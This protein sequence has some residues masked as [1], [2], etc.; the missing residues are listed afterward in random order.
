MDIVFKNKGFLSLI[1]L[2]TIGDSIKAEDDSKIGKFDSGLKYALSILYRNGIEVIISS[3]NSLYTFD[4]TILK[5]E[6]SNKVKEVLVI[7]EFRSGEWFTHTTAFSPKFGKDWEVWMAIRELYSNCLDEN[8]S[9]NFS[10]DGTYFLHSDDTVVCIKDNSLL[11]ELRIN[12][13]KYFIPSIE[14]PLMHVGNVKVYKNSGDT[15]RLYKSGILIHKDEHVFSK[16]S[17]DYSQASIDEMRCL[18]DL[19]NFKYRIVDAIK[20]CETEEFIKNFIENSDTDSFEASLDF[21][22][23]SF[24]DKWVETVNNYFEVNFKINTY[25]K[26]QKALYNDKRF[27]LDKVGICPTKDSYS[28]NK[29]LVTPESKKEAILSFEETILELCK[30]INYKVKFPIVKSQISGYKCL[31]DLDR[32]CL[33]VTEDFKEENLWE[34]VKAQ[35]RLENDSYDYVYKEYIKLLKK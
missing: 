32:K 14:V 4:S 35:M 29:V 33:Y 20:E 13:A 30:S 31:A 2:T 22:Y 23:G 25:P 27:K 21:D 6:V 3:G 15:L 18:N 24:N 5:D 26:L 8:G 17:Y 1:D 7:K 12:W 9:I 34:L 11:E 28:W 19:D 10:S 16:Y